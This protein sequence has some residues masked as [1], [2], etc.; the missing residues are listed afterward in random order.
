MLFSKRGL[1]AGASAFL[2]TLLSS[3]SKGAPTT[4]AGANGLDVRLFG[5]IGNGIADDTAAIQAAI[6]Q[7]ISWS[8]AGL[9]SFEVLIP[10]GQY[11][12][13][14][15]LFVMSFSGGVY[16]YFSVTIR[17]PSE[18]YI[19]GEKTAILPNF[20]TLPAFIVQQGRNIKFEGF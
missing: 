8:V 14:S 18:G 10:P 13:S 6:N 1:I 20:K 11:L 19:L 3:S 12:I 5:A 16:S 9:G 15:P 4:I 2:G 7:A 17:G